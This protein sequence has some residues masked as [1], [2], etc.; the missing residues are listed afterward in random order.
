[1]DKHL[2]VSSRSL[3]PF[4]PFDTDNGPDDRAALLQDAFS[5]RLRRERAFL[6]RET[7]DQS[8]PMCNLLRR[9]RTETQASRLLYLQAHI[10]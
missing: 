7:R 2:S 8:P 5:A 9:W 10:C 1:M 3:C 6:S 4:V